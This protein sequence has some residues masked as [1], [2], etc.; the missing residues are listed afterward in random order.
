MEEIREA[1]ERARANASPHRQRRVTPQSS[2]QSK[3]VANGSPQLDAGKEVELE[4]AFLRSKRIVGHDHMEAQSAAFDMLRTQVLQ[5]M[6]AKEWRFLGITSPTPGCGK[7]VIAV[8]LGLSIARLTE[9]TVLLMDLDLRKPQVA[10]DLGLKPQHGTI[11]IL[12]GRST[13]SESIIQTRIDN[14]RMMVLPTESRVSGSSDWMA[15]SAMSEML[16]EIKGQSQ[17]RIVIVDL[18]PLL[19]SDDVL[20]VLPQL[21]CVVLVTAV[22][23]TRIAEINESINHLQSTELVRIVLNKAPPSKSAYYY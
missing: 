18:P 11:S 3:F 2:T 7:T 15:S 19:A 17:W 12:E 10:S 22:G 9:K 14:Y 16:E 23:T 4:R 1:L 13:L 5:S 8:N 20:S 6:D 21:D